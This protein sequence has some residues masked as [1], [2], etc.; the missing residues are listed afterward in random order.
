MINNKITLTKRERDCLIQIGEYSDSPFPLRLIDLSERLQVS[1]P[2]VLSLIKG[3]E[4]K[5]LVNRN[6][7]MV[8]LT[9][10]GKN[11]YRRIVESHRVMEV[12]MVKNGLNPDNACK[13]S[14]RFDFMLDHED[15]LKIF[16]SLGKPECCPHGR[17]IEVM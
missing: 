12:L 8:M 1:S 14:S 11:Q 5:G 4:G 3:L 9:E 10:T 17:K 6:H 7:G 16:F 13:E 15:I 2:A